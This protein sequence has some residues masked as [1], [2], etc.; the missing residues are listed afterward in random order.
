MLYIGWPSA[1]LHTLTSFRGCLFRVRVLKR[2]VSRKEQRWLMWRLPM[3][4]FLCYLSRNADKPLVSRTFLPGS[5]QNVMCHHWTYIRN[6]VKNKGTR[7]VEWKL[8]TSTD[9][10]CCWRWV[11]L[12]KC[13][14][15]VE[16]G[17]L[18]V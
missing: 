2:L 6:C 17:N 11:R 5:L 4:Q 1:Y 8:V 3:Q 15:Y 18:S 12:V 10:T 14:H 13:A 16:A 9:G 7:T